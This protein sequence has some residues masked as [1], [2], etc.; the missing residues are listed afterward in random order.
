VATNKSVF[1]G[2]QT[3]V[4]VMREGVSV[5]WICMMALSWALEAHTEGAATQL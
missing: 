1:V 3:N 2:K 4:S 5:G